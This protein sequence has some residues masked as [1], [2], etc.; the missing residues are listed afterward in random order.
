VVSL[1][2]ANRSK[3]ISTIRF[4]NP[5]TTKLA[6]KA[7]SMK[8]W[9]THLTSARAG[10]RALK[11]VRRRAKRFS[12]KLLLSPKLTRKQIR[13]LK[14]STRNSYR[15]LMMT[16]LISLANLTLL[17]AKTELLVKAQTLKLSRQT[18]RAKGLTLCRCF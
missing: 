12:K 9:S 18:K 5:V 4:R 11:T 6:T 13:N 2:K 16:T 14:A 3:T 7:N 1:T 8:K 15:S 10:S 17:D